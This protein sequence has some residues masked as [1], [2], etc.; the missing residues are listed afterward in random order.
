MYK[1]GSLSSRQKGHDLLFSSTT[2]TQSCGE[3][4]R[5]GKSQET[6]GPQGS[7]CLKNKKRFEDLVPKV[8]KWEWW[9]L[10]TF[11]LLWYYITSKS[12]WLGQWFKLGSGPASYIFF[13]KWT[14]FTDCG[15]GPVHLYSQL[16]ELIIVD[17]LNS[18]WQAGVDGLAIL[19]T[20]SK[21]CCI[22]IWFAY[23]G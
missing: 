13:K 8:L 10:L 11:V 18:E 4:C 20:C 16:K 7:T 19:K 14:D 2:I 12:T 22:F 6:W 5:R 9:E 23:Q 3:T 17:Y 1:W 15:N 21:N